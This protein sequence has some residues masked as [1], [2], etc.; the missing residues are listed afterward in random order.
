MSHISKIL[1][2]GSATPLRAI[3]ELNGIY[4]LIEIYHEFFWNNVW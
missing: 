2:S 3:C 1:S 4:K